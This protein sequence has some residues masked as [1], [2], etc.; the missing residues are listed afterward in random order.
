MKSSAQTLPFHFQAVVPTSE[1]VSLG[2]QIRHLNI[3]L[4]ESA[5]SQRDPF[6]TPQPRQLLKTQWDVSGKYCQPLKIL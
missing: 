3:P 4:Q 1:T 6:S 2:S 5:V